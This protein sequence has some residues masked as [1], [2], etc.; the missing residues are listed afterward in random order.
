PQSGHRAKRQRVRWGDS[1]RPPPWE[2]AP[3]RTAYCR[4]PRAR[5]KKPEKNPWRGVP[6]RDR[7]PQGSAARIAPGSA[8]RVLRSFPDKW[9]IPA[10]RAVR[11]ASGAEWSAPSVPHRRDRV[12]GADRA[13]WARKSP[14][15]PFPPDARNHWWRRNA[16]SARTA[17]FSSSECDRYS[18]GLR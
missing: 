10:R 9:S 2:F 16:W 18:S 1:R 4:D 17:E 5:E 8:A 11:V 14:P 7:G 13:A 15:H 6:R 3:V 12:R